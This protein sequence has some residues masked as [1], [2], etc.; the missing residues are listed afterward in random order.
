MYFP[1]ATLALAFA[2]QLTVFPANFDVREQK[3]TGAVRRGNFS[4]GILMAT[5]LYH[6]TR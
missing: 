2:V 3:T 4:F 1:F 6:V 5:I